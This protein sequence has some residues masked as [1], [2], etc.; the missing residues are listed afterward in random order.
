M[1]AAQSDNIM[2]KMMMWRLGYKMKAI[3]AMETDM[4]AV[5]G[6]GELTERSSNDR[7]VININQT[8]IGE[9]EYEKAACVSVSR[10][11]SLGSMT[12]RRL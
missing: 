9:V 4:T 11:S 2:I 8:I 7:L 10:T 3:D 1:L 6:G 12:D 5:R